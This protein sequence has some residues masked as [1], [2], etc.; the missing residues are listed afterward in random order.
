MLEHFIE[1]IDSEWIPNYAPAYL[2]TRDR[3]ALAF[4]PKL[5]PPPKKDSK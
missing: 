1:F 3:K 4:L 5:L 2:E